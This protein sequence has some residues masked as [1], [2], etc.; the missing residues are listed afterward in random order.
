MK[1]SYP[2]IQTLDNVTQ[3][4]AS[5]NTTLTT[6]EE[7]TEYDNLSGLSHGFENIC[8]FTTSVVNKSWTSN[9]A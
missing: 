9:S 2:E 8:T 1:S 6:P 4:V 3:Y 7:I 5:V